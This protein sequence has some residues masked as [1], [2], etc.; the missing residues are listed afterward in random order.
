[1]DDGHITTYKQTVLNTNSF[2]FE[3]ITFLQSA[4]LIKLGFCTRTIKKC[5]NQ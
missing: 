4:L 3:E 1:M 5:E 2:S